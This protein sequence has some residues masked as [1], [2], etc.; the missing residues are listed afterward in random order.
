VALVNTL[1]ASDEVFKRPGDASM[2]SRLKP[3]MRKTPGK[4]FSFRR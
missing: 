3:W 4:Y 2:R 1:F